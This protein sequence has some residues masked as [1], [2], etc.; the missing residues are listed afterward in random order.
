MITNRTYPSMTDELQIFLPEMA[1]IVQIEQLTALEK[2]FTIELPAGRSL[3]HRPGQ[4]VEVSFLG[5]GEAPISIS[6]SPSRS[7]GIFELCV[8][9]VG[10]VTGALHRLTPGDKIGI[11]GPYGHGFPI[12]RFRGKDMLFA[13]GGLGLAP[14][15]SLINQ[16]MDERAQFGRVIILY[17]ARTPSELLFKD[18]LK[19]W[20]E[21]E[22]VE[23]YLTVDRG[24]ATWDGHIGVI[25]TLFKDI[26]INPRNTV[27]VTVGPPVMYRFVLME[28]LGKGIPEGNIWLSLERRMKCGV[29]KCGH[30][31]IN[32]I[33]TC[34]SGPV[35]SYR[36]IKGLEEAL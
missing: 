23:L 13:P 22:D 20:G 16:V 26:S 10:D 14:A 5:V 7:N 1:R 3:D 28:L 35:F 12:E 29:G 4:F 36:D 17:G 21:R 25:T 27:A 31:Q 34:Q 19:R 11:R 8:R 15:R 2:L 33:Y 32:N 24:D 30:C 18:E 9:K 6:S